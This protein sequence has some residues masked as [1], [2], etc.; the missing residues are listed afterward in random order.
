M[1]EYI[2]AF[3]PTKPKFHSSCIL[4]PLVSVSKLH[5]IAWKLFLQ[6]PIWILY[7]RK[8]FVISS[9]IAGLLG[10]VRVWVARNECICPSFFRRHL[11]FLNLSWHTG[12]HFCK[13]LC[14]HYGITRSLL[15][16]RYCRILSVDFDELEFF[17]PTFK[18]YYDKW[19]SKSNR[20]SI[21]LWFPVELL[22]YFLWEI[23]KVN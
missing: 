10:Q 16:I 5:E 14:L 4:I 13:R 21:W 8:K 3:S 15:V 19:K 1:W 2:Y 22:H 23:P 7:C 9:R 20:K 12:M 17:L 6:S 18:A 11:C